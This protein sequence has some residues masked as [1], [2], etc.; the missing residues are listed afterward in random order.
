MGEPRLRSQ[1]TCPSTLR[2]SSCSGS[3]KSCFCLPLFAPQKAEVRSRSERDGGR[4]GED[5]Y[6]SAFDAD[7]KPIANT[8]QG[9]FPVLNTNDDGY[10]GLA[11][12]GC[13]KPNGYGLYDMIGNV[14]EWTS[15]WYRPGHSPG[16]EADP[17]GPNLVS[18]RVAPGE[19]SSRV[20]KGGSYL[21]A[22]NFCARYRPAAR[23]PQ[24]VDLSAAHL[25]FRTVLNKPAATA[26]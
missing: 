21:C 14:W 26:P 9:I 16:M 1:Q 8:W 2:R 10:G 25:G 7:G 22:L 5:D 12:V 4:D 18:L 24:E 3:P 11:P 17:A 15:D 20:I 13:F 23:Q 19:A 6:A